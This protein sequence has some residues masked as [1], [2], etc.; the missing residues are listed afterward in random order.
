MPTDSVLLKFAKL[1][2]NAFSP[3]RGSKLAAGY[4]LYRYYIC[5]F[6]WEFLL[7]AQRYQFTAKTC[8]LRRGHWMNRSCLQVT[9]LHNFAEYYT[10]SIT[11]RP[12]YLCT[13][14]GRIGKGP[15]GGVNFEMRRTSLYTLTDSVID[16]SYVASVQIP[17]RVA[18]EQR[19]KEGAIRP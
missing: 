3:T 19:L 4:D 1:S 2:K 15:R 12:R 5:V 17:N 16:G 14:Q 18:Y 6:S 8:K 9:I 11:P 7:L 13:E 10:Y